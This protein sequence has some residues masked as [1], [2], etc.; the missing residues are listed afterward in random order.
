MHRPACKEW[1]DGL[2]YLL[3]RPEE[4]PPRNGRFPLIIFLHGRGESAPE[5]SLESLEKLKTRGLPRLAS[6]GPLPRVDGRDFPFLVAA[7]QAIGQ[8]QPDLARLARLP[9]VMIDR[10]GADPSR[11]YLTGISMG[12]VACWRVA[13]RAP[14]RFA[15]LLPV[16]GRI[17]A[18]AMEARDIPAWVFAGGLD[19]HYPARRVQR[20][21]DELR[22]RGAEIT[23]TVDPD[24]GH[25]QAFWGR[26][27]ATSCIYHWLLDHRR[28][29]RSR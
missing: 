24:A 11:C 18:E 7:P 4:R 29:S 25:D 23:L 2:P 20:E 6:A 15:A 3:F 17:P 26:V 14:G 5:R 27:Y 13:Q 19:K 21:L 8:W 1:Y 9:E 10:H 22:S 16:S 12:A 28:G